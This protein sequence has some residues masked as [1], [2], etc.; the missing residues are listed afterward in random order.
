MRAV[1]V[2]SS[3][4]PFQKFLPGS[5]PKQSFPKSKLKNVYLKISVSAIELRF[6]CTVFRQHRGAGLWNE[7]SS[8]GARALRCVEG[9]ARGTAGSG[10]RGMLRAL[11]AE[12]QSYHLPFGQGVA[13]A[14]LLNSNAIQLSRLIY[15]GFVALSPNVSLLMT[16]ACPD[17]VSGLTAQPI[18]SNQLCE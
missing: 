6:P 17:F 3:E 12:T 11:A 2:D 8:P 10:N 5:L 16:S 14:W 18:Q 4:H 9:E 15:D 1:E 13:H 7:M